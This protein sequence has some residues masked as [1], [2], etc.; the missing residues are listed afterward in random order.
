MK[1]RAL[2]FAL[3]LPVSLALGGCAADASDD[4]DD[5]DD[6]D[7]ESG[8]A[9]QEL[10]LRGY[11]EPTSAHRDAA[12]TRFAHVDPNGVVPRAL[13]DNAL[14]FVVANTQRVNHEDYVG[15]IDYAKHSGK[16]RFFVVNLES[17][18][19]SAHVV[20]HGSGSDPG[21]SGFA[22]SFGNVSG[23]NRTSLGYF[24]TAETYYGRAGYSLRLDGVSDTNSRARGR[25]IVIHGA[26]YVDSWRTKQGRSWGC[27][28]VPEGERNDII[29]KLRDG[30][31]IYA[32]RSDVIDG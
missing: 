28:A 30:R 11:T 19:V 17:G 29:R 12:R 20:A 13:L 14:A 21:N 7:G 3:A 18:A 2:L 26:S 8:E 1:L 22:K 23:S 25:N 6:A 10:V 4:V 15:V 16:K 27:P 31:V 32:E 24:L 9:A 5:A